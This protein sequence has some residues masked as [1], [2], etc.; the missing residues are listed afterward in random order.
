MREWF[1][2]AV[3][4]MV[5]FG[6]LSLAPTSPGSKR[7]TPVAGAGCHSVE[8]AAGEEKDLGVNMVKQVC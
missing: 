1:G 7:V 2:L 3:G 5:D 8:V 6:C 4:F